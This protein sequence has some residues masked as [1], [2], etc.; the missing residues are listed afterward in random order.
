MRAH[1]RLCA[2]DEDFA[3]V[4]LFILNNKHH[5][6]HSITTVYMITQL[7]SYLTDGYLIQIL[8]ADDTVIGAT[9]YYHGT[10]EQEFENK[11]IAFVDLAILDPTYRGSRVFVNGL[12]YLNNHIREKHPE[13]QE[14]HFM[15]LS[16]NSYLCRLY[17]KF[18]EVS[19][20]REG[21]IGIESVY[22]VK[23]HKLKTSLEKFNKV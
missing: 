11:E 13:V 21:V 2:T 12:Q 6:H 17:G 14:L 15:A 23:V 5:L 9:A 3:K 10:P 1:S 16:E 20:S 4:S 22:C 19:H 7:Y 18:A 8:D